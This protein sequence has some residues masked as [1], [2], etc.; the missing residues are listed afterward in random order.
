MAVNI[1]A[2]CRMRR[3]ERWSV[4]RSGVANV[5]APNDDMLPSFDLAGKRASSRRWARA[6]AEIDITGEGGALA[7]KTS[8]AD[9]RPAVCGGGATSVCLCT[10]CV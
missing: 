2:L 3:C 4:W 5:K 10:L 6:H 8:G 9:W 1:E 7:A